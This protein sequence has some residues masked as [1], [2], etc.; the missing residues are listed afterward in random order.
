MGWLDALERRAREAAAEPWR[1]E[2]VMR[3]QL[4]WY[5]DKADKSPRLDALAAAEGDA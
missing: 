2:L 3:E 5:D 1:P 4:K